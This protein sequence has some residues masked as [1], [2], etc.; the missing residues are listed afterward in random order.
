M[1]TQER[2]K[3]SMFAWQP[4]SKKEK[5]ETRVTDTLLP[6]RLALCLESKDERDGDSTADIYRDLFNHEGGLYT[7]TFSQSQ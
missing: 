6:R 7:G 5:S 3:R 1:I 4:L 2:I